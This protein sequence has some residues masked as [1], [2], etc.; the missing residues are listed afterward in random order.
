MV[1]SAETLSD[2]RLR[3]PCAGSRHA[4]SGHYRLRRAETLKAR[5]YRDHVARVVLPTDADAGW[6]RN[7]ADPAR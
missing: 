5:A 2:A 4:G 3:E 7:I 6:A 1:A